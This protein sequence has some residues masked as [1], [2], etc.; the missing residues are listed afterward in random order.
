MLCVEIEESGRRP[1]NSDRKTQNRRFEILDR[2][3]RCRTGCDRRKRYRCV[4]VRVG[5]NL[6]RRDSRK[7]ISSRLGCG[8]RE[9]L[10][11]PADMPIRLSFGYIRITAAEILSGPITPCNYALTRL[12]RFLENPVREFRS[13]FRTFSC[14]AVTCYAHEVGTVII[15]RRPTRTEGSRRGHH[16]LPEQNPEQN[17]CREGVPTIFGTKSTLRSG[18][19][20]RFF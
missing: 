6:Y 5:Q 14:D 3:R 20:K 15:A 16:G 11:D 8:C 1:R 9:G 7:R 13:F 17:V 10:A 12:T 2:A 4:L 19:Q 18:A